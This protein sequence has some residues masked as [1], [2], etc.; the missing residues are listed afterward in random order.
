MENL[1]SRKLAAVIAA[2]TG[3]GGYQVPARQVRAGRQAGQDG[4]GR[5]RGSTVVYGSAMGA[6]EVTGD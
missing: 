6:E 2:I 5:Q 3:L 4:S 1:S